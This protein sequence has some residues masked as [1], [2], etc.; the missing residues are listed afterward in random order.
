[1]A[2]ISWND[3]RMSGQAALESGEY[4]ECLQCWNEAL[5]EAK[6][7]DENSLEVATSCVD[8]ANLYNVLGQPAEAEES[9][10]N[11][12]KI[13]E[14]HLGR[15]DLQVA[16]ALNMLAKNYT[17]QGRLAEANELY[18]DALQIR[19]NILGRNHIDVAD[20]Y[21][22]LAIFNSAIGKYESCE[23]LLQQALGIRQTL[24]ADQPTIE[25]ANL[26][27]ALARNYRKLA[28]YEDADEYYRKAL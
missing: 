15:Q 20:S 4:D 21:Q 13:R 1:M 14:N 19:E 17:H 24:A 16:E 18:H 11:A 5:A 8:L 9:L 22:E 26:L 23:P 12:I 10:L 28:R 6:K 27:K 7:A 3:L 2:E 25:V